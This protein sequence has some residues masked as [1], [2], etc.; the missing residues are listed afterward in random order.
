[1]PDA[2]L[3]EV[4]VSVSNQS[5]IDC[6]DAVEATGLD[7]PEAASEKACRLPIAARLEADPLPQSGTP[8]TDPRAHD[9]SGAVPLR[10]EPLMFPAAFRL[11]KA[12]STPCA[13]YGLVESH[14]GEA[15]AP[16]TDADVPNVGAG[17]AASDATGCRIAMTIA[18]Q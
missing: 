16:C 14:Q 17:T 9:E 12:K 18:G 3:A 13:S 11:S 5:A 2:R 1:M 15:D 4:I 10:A 6:A 7:T 8:T